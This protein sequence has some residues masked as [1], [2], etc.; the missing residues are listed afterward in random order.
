[1]VVVQVRFFK[2]ADIAFEFSE[3]LPD[4][5]QTS[6]M[7]HIKGFATV[8]SPTG[9]VLGTRNVGDTTDTSVVNCPA[10]IVTL[11]AETDECQ[12]L[13]ISKLDDSRV[14]RQEQRLTDGQELIINNDIKALLIISGEVSLNGLDFTGPEVIQIKSPSVRLVSV[15]DSFVSQLS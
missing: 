9:E 13:C 2:G 8:Y 12:Y 3:P 5:E 11:T 10:G 14:V 1:M 4:T 6:Y 7:V 15:G